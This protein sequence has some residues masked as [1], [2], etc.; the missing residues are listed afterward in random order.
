M[1]PVEEALRRILGRTRRLPTET[2]TLG[3]ARGR[4]LR[5][6]VFADRDLPPFD[7][8]AVDGYAVRAACLANGGRLRVVDQV[9]AGAMPR[10]PVGPGEAAAVM[11][12][13]PV[14]E[15]GRLRDHGG[16]HGS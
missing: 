16:R 8:S 13:A 5:E 6:D 14:P 3:K 12:G 4:V 2:V 10:V 7:R 1:I 11:T 15:G 9:P